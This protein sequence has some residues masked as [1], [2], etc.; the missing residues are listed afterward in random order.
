MNSTGSLR[1]P[2]RK[3]G[4][5]PIYVQVAEILAEEV[6]RS[7][8]ARFALP[9]EG[10]LS[11]QFGVSRVTIR[12]ALKQLE[13]RGLIYSEHG[14]GYFKSTSRMRGV[15]GFHSFTE[16][17]ARL[18]GKPATSLIGF[19][20]PVALPAEF[21]RHLR[22]DAPQETDFIHL[23][24]VRSIDNDPV[25]VEDIY[26]PASMYRG[27][28]RAQFDKPSLYA[29]MAGTWGV[30][31]AWA[32]ALFEPVSASADEAQYLRVKPGTPLLAVWRV[33][34]SDTDQAIEYVRSVYKGDGFML[35]VT[36]Y[37]L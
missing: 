15:S 8:D 12:Q 31:P 37:R 28:T 25:A 32:D 34:A 5:A 10:E 2:L 16:E 7:D 14:R 13:T 30:S 1:Q 19:A 11:R 29:E 21:R 9:S 4:A 22:S 6:A 23:R 3:V 24:R 36:R 33:T 17:V 18:G 26:L 27:A 20:D 35:N